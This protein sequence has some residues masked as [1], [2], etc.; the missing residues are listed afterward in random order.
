VCTL[1]FNLTDSSCCI[2]LITQSRAIFSN[3][4]REIEMISKNVETYPCAAIGPASVRHVYDQ[5][6]ND[7]LTIIDYSSWLLVPCKDSWI[8]TQHRN[9]YIETPVL[10]SPF[11]FP[12][13]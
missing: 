6:C 3:L 5:V 9:M 7:L 8:E 13:F 4:P 2:R 11:I 10:A 1:T 12:P